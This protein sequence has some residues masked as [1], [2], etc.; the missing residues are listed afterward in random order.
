MKITNLKIKNFRGFENESINFDDITVFV[1]ENNTGKTTI[2]DAIRFVIGAKSFNNISRYDYYLNS[3]TA[4]HGD[5]G[6]IEL[7]IEV[8]EQKENDWPPEIQQIL[9]DCVDIDG[10]GL[11]H[12]YLAYKGTYDQTN[13]RSESVKEFQTKTGAPKNAKA[14]TPHCFGEFKKL[15]P[16]FH[17]DTIRDS[18]KEFQS[19]SGLFQTFLNSETIA[20]EQKTNL[21]Q[22][23]ASLNSEIIGVLGNLSKLKD[24][25]KQS[26]SVIAGSETAT[27]DIDPMPT[28][29]NDLIGKAAVILHSITGIK[30][31]LERFGSGAQSL[32]VLF[33]YEAFLTVL[34]EEKYDKFSEPILLIEEPEAHLHPSAVRLFWRFLTA[35]PGQKII[36]T[37]SG[38]ILSNVPFSKIRRIV[39]V[40]GVN[41]IKN[42]SEA[43]F[44]DQEKRI[45]NNYIKYSRGELFFA[46]SWLLV[47]GES[48]QAFFNNLLNQDGFLDREGI[49]IIQF[50]QLGGIDVILKLIEAFGVKWFLITD[51]DQAGQDY[52]QK[53]N[54][55]IPPNKNKDNFLFKFPEKTIEVHLMNIGYNNIYEKYLTPANKQKIPNLGLNGIAYYEKIYELLGEQKRNHKISKPLIILEIIDHILRSGNIPKII[56][57]IKT[58]LETINE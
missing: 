54:I 40:K 34:L 45:L 18:N 24:K 39:G 12:F 47:E 35:M 46:R 26:M 42:M 53:A 30:L 23:L 21:E 38:D 55:A 57:Y 32:S 56:P 41:R 49:R 52:V 22:K 27:V 8:S 10:N 1:G 31:P 16:V 48:E 37:H 29:I 33:L 19:S 17:I 11:C 50:S 4:K 9:P 43:S 28:N 3:P 36:T 58:K 6:N 14:N 51:G 13:E 15:L 7:S 44:N 2:L 20:P 25:L 5:A